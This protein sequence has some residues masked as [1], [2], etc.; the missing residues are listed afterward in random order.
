MPRK[1]KQ[2]HRMFIF[3]AEKIVGDPFELGTAEIAG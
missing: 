1:Q 3:P 2:F